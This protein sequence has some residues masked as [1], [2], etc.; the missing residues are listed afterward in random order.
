[1][2]I[3]EH[4]FCMLTMHPNLFHPLVL[5]LVHSMFEV[6]CGMLNSI[7]LMALAFVEWWQL[8]RNQLGALSSFLG[9]K[10]GQYREVEFLWITQTLSKG[11]KLQKNAL[12]I[13]Q[14]KLILVTETFFK[15]VSVLL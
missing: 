9:Q 1:M 11:L 6:V 12:M 10:N 5:L 4:L 14:I 2:K 7:N 3:Q 15:L 8:Q 13:Q